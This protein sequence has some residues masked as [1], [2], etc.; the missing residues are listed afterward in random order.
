VEKGQK[1]S[2]RQIIGTLGSTG[3]S[4]GPHLHYEFLINGVHK[5]PRTV[6]LPQANPIKNSERV[7]FEQLTKPL[8]AQ[9]KSHQKT[10]KLAMILSSKKQKSNN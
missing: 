6:A 9:L 1:V 4:T 5:N 2:Q 7:R 10:S 8:V 3:Y